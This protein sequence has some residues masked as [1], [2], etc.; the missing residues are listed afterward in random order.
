MA[1]PRITSEVF[2]KKSAINSQ[3]YDGFNCCFIHFMPGSYHTEPEVIRPNKI[4]LHNLDNLIFFV[5]E[6]LSHGLWRSCFTLLAYLLHKGGMAPRDSPVWE[7][8]QNPLVP[9]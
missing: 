5:R 1:S 2:F 8:F 9:D 6:V 3:C 4:K 7:S